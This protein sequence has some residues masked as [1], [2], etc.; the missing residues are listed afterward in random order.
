MVTKN[1]SCGQGKSIQIRDQGGMIFT[2][3]LKSVLGRRDRNNNFIFP[4]GCHFKSISKPRINQGQSKC[5]MV[6]LR[7]ST[8]FS[9]C[10]DKYEFFENCRMGSSKKG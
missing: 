8:N 1:N 6:K 9:G 2:M 3:L 5:L 7:E 10:A 4:K